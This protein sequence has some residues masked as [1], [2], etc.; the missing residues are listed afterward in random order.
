L[1]VFALATNQ[2]AAAAASPQHGRDWLVTMRAMAVQA[3]RLK[4]NKDCREA[5][6]KGAIC[7]RACV[8]ACR[9]LVEAG[10]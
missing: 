2:A 1:E 8:R 10:T 7:V 9:L 4:V 3:L 5:I 6:Q